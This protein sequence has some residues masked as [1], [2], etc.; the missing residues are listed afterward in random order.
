MSKSALPESSPLIRIPC[1]RT[2]AS[3]EGDGADEKGEGAFETNGDDV[4]VRAGVSAGGAYEGGFC[5]P[6]A[7]D[8]DGFASGCFRHMETSIV[9]EYSRPPQARVPGNRL[10]FRNYSTEAGACKHNDKKKCS[11]KGNRGNSMAG[12]EFPPPESTS[13]MATTMPTAS[14]EKILR[15]SRVLH[16]ESGS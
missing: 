16:H 9:D 6:G 7:T 14:W 10:R 4:G 12:F 8:G 1:V 15:P 11:L 5:A 13:Q 3:A 2:A